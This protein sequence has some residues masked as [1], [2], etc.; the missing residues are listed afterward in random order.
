MA[1]IK[2]AFKGKKLREE[3]FW[4]LF[5]DTYSNYDYWPKDS[6]FKNAEEREAKWRQHKSE[7]MGY[8]RENA[9]PGCRPGGWLDFESP[10]KLR[11]L[12]RRP[13]GPA[14]CYHTGRLITSLPIY[15]KEEDALARMGLLEEWEKEELEKQGNR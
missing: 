3:E 10:E 14:T 15:E 13:F 4:D 7:I 1:R 12:G 8:W 2:R 9:N 5:L 11:V 6:P